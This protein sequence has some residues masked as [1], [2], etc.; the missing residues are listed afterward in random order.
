MLNPYLDESIKRGKRQNKTTFVWKW[1]VAQPT[2][3]S[4]G[5]WVA[6]RPVGSLGRTPTTS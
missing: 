2:Q 1:G 3:C 4:G 6:I 5:G